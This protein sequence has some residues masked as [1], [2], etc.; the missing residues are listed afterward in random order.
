[1]AGPSSSTPANSRSKNHASFGSLTSAHALFDADAVQTTGLPHRVADRHRG[2]RQ[3]HGRAPGR[4][5][6]DGE[7]PDRRTTAFSPAAPP[8]RCSSCADGSNSIDTAARSPRA[9]KTMGYCAGRL[10]PQSRRVS[11]QSGNHTDLPA[12]QIGRQLR[13]PT[14]VK[15]ED[16]AGPM[17]SRQSNAL[18]IRRPCD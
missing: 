1:M 14:G 8:A 4:Q 17:P 2:Q 12:D 3:G 7:R 10:R 15:S 6:R 16:A 13:Q 11:R 9:S 5:H 18:A